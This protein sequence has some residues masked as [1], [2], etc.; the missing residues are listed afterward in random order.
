MKKGFSLIESILVITLLG[1]MFSGIAIFIQ[2]SLNSW[3][4]F[5]A[6]KELLSEATGAM[7]RM[8]RELRIADKNV[9]II[10]HTPTQ[11]TIR[12]KLGHEI[13][14]AQDGSSLKRNGV[15]LAGNLAD[16]GGLS[17]RYLRDDGTDDPNMSNVSS[18][19]IRLT[20]VKENSK[21][22]LE[23]SAAIRI[24]NL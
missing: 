13:S 12:D 8:T 15:I 20:L 23:S 18:I 2:E 11:V 6:Q 24:K 17:L 9:S 22:A 3:L 14:F 5:S 19:W 21:V 4:F 16:P 10:V 1:L 7:N